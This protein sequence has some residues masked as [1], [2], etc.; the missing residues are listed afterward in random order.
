MIGSIDDIVKTANLSKKFIGLILMP[1]VGNAAEHATA[2]VVAITDKM[3]L[4]MAVA[5]GSAIQ[6][7]LLA[8]PALVMVGWAKGKEM[9][10][11]FELC[12]FFFCGVDVVGVV[13]EKR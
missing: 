9:S 5:I 11:Q 12:K 10:L 7:A 6:I 3:D 8:A 2:C 13:N 1:I 4:A